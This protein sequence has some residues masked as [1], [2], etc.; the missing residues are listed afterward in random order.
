MD[1]SYRN[2]Q[3]WTWCDALF[4]APAAYL[5]IANIENDTTYINATHKQF[6][7]TYNHLF[8]KEEK[9]FFRDDS[10]FEKREENGEKVFWGRGNGWVVAGLANIIDLLP[11][12]ISVKPFYIDLFREMSKKL[13]TLQHEDGFWHASLLDSNSY[14]W[15]ET[16][17]TALITYGLAYGINNEILKD[18]CFSESMYKAW[19]AL[20]TAIN[21][22]GKIGW[23]QPIG[24]DPKKVTKEMTAVYGVGA[25][26]NGCY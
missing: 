12:N 3:T 25:F 20:L 5:G 13:V 18:K 2:K 26:F 11:D 19:T 16:S 22:E 14:P 4:M 17:A 23:V 24:A 10:Y 9:L 1:M 15:P 8:D 6:M 21:E 7:A